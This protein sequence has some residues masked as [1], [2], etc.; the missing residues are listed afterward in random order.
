MHSNRN[1]GGEIRGQ[2]IVVPEP[3]AIGTLALGALTL[4]ARRRNA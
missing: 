2:L 4:L 1:T 3:A